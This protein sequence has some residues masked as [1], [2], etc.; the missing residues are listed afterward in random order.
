MTSSIN[1][2]RTAPSANA[3]KR[4]RSLD[5]GSDIKNSLFL[6]LGLIEARQWAKFEAVALSN[7]RDFRSISEAITRCDCFNGMTLL[8]ACVRFDVSFRLL[9]EMIKLYPKAL[10]SKD[11]MGRTPLHVAAGSSACPTIVK[12]LTVEYPQACAVQD[13]DGMTPLHFACDT[14]C[15]LFE[16]DEAAPRGSPKLTTVRILLAGSLDAV[17]LEDAD[18]MNP[19]EYALLSDASMEVINLLQRAS[20]RVLKKK[21]KNQKVQVSTRPTS[22]TMTQVATPMTR[23]MNVMASRLCIQ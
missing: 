19:I 23:Q 10:S 7:P 5:K 4:G 17:V 22:Q 2:V 15:Q 21:K 18:E 8:H 3:S 20:L 1:F 6:I 12:R 13:E 11:F 16:D 9:D 14:T